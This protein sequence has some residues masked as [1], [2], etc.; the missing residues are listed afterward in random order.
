MPTTPYDTLKKDMLDS[1]SEDGEMKSPSDS[2]AVGKQCLGVNGEHVGEGTWASL[3]VRGVGDKSRSDSS[4][5]DKGEAD[6]KRGSTLAKERLSV[7]DRLRR[8]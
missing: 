2:S 3:S 6:T 5:K 4:I 1:S 8:R 7:K